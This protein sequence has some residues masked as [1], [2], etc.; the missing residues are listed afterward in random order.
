VASPAVLSASSSTFNAGFQLSGQGQIRFR[1]SGACAPAGL[2]GATGFISSMRLET[3][4]SGLTKSDALVIERLLL[5]MRQ[6]DDLWNMK[7]YYPDD[8]LNIRSITD[9]TIL[10]MIDQL[11]D[12]LIAMHRLPT[13]I[14]KTPFSDTGIDN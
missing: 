12:K 5:L 2:G 3:V 13:Y 10:D 8:D 4:A 7:D 1:G 14:N 6:K 9:Q 11:S